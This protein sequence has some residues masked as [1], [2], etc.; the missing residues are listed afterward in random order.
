MKWI[1]ALFVVGFLLVG[2]TSPAWSMSNPTPK[3][4]STANRKVICLAKGA[5]IRRDT[6]T[7]QCYGGRIYR[8]AAGKKFV[9]VGPYVI[10]VD[11]GGV[12]GNSGILFRPPAST[13]NM[14]PLGALPP[15]PPVPDHGQRIYR[16]TK[17]NDLGEFV[18]CEVFEDGHEDCIIYPSQQS[19]LKG[20]LVP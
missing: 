15:L 8:A 11:S 9:I 3:I 2:V 6:K 16:Y 7:V 19:E 1:I 10:E 20:S 18:E 12:L 13:K 5:V 14:F 4:T 17:T